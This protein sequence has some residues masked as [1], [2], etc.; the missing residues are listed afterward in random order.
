MRVIDFGRPVGAA[1]PPFIIAALDCRE[2]GTLERALAAVDV[3]ADSK[4]DAIKLA[5]LPSGWAPQLF[6][7]AERRNLMMLA[8]AL[9]EEQ[10]SRL[11]WMGAPAF[12]LV[13]DWSDLELVARAAQTGKPIVMQV[14]TASEAELAEIVATARA[15]GTGGIVLV[16][17]VIDVELEGLEA[18]RRHGAVVGIA[19]R[20]RGVQIPRAAIASGVPVIEKRFVLRGD[21]LLCPKEVGEVVQDCEQLWASMS[22]DRRWAFN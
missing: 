15:N 11:D 6:A 21:D 10:I 12:Y 2:L 18:L 13:F 3:A 20:S 14:G 1:H 8:T 19:D 9:D 22:D 5:R 16:Q 17:S 4:V 7:R